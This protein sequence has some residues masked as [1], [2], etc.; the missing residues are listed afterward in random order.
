MV[1]GKEQKWLYTYVKYV[2]TMDYHASRKNDYAGL[3]EDGRGMNG[4]HTDFLPGQIWNYNSI[5]EKPPGA[6]N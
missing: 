5:M 1:I 4:N 2:Y 6:N 3:K